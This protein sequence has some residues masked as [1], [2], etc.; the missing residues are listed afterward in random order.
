MLVAEL[1]GHDQGARGAE[2]AVVEG[3]QVAGHLEVNGL[4]ALEGQ[5]Q[6]LVNLLGGV[7]DA[8]DD[9][10]VAGHLGK[11]KRESRDEVS[12]GGTKK[13]ERERERETHLLVAVEGLAEVW[14]PDG[15][16][17]DAL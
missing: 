15:V 6:A 8:L 1:G 2:G 13:R 4:L 7:L 17:E 5:L 9:S 12:E 3:W 14:D 11:T 16:V 10:L